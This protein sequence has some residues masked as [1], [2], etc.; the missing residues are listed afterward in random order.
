MPASQ[1]YIDAC[2]LS[3]KNDVWSEVLPFT[4]NHISFF[5]NR[6][7]FTNFYI[8]QQEQRLKND[9]SYLQTFYEKIFIA[10]IINGVYA[11]LSFRPLRTKWLYAYRAL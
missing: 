4:H 9:S 5:R 6:C 3:N 10:E 7:T 2:I 11:W 8:F 1:Y